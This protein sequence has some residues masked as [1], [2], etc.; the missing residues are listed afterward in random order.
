MHVGLVLHHMLLETCWVSEW[1]VRRT[2]DS[3]WSSSVGHAVLWS[4]HTGDHVRW[5][6]RWIDWTTI[7]SAQTTSTIDHHT[8]W[9]HWTWDTT[10]SESRSGQFDV[11]VTEAND[12]EDGTSSI[13]FDDRIQTW[14]EAG[15]HE[16]IDP[17]DDFSLELWIWK[18]DHFGDEVTREGLVEIFFG[19]L[20][21][22]S[23]VSQVGC[24]A[25]V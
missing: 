2:R 10:V 5:N 16:R 6:H 12:S 24:G 4:S 22:D 7:W 13:G 20:D 21:R 8:P 15:A 19:E 9:A 25:W 1:N 14:L 11:F 3:D 23:V 18:I 17:G